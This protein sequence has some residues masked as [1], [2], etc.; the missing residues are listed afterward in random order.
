MFTSRPASLLPPIRASSFFYGSHFASRQTYTH[1][2]EQKHVPLT[3]I[4]Y[5]KMI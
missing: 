4:A 1:A 2:G 5:E 3:F